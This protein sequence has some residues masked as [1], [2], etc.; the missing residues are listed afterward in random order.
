MRIRI[1]VILVPNVEK[2]EILGVFGNDNFNIRLFLD[3]ELNKSI[4][5]FFRSRYLIYP[6][7]YN[8]IGIFKQKN[9][10]WIEMEIDDRAYEILMSDVDK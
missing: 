4:E 7:S 6:Y 2:E 5:R 3:G 10:Y 1:K 8:I 9:H